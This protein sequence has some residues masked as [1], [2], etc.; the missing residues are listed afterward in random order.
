[1]AGSKEQSFL[2][3]G[4][5]N[6]KDAMDCFRWH[7]QSKCHSDAVQVMVVLPKSVRDVGKTITTAYAQ[8]KAENRKVLMKILQNIK[9]LGHQGI[10]LW[11][12]DDS[13]S[14]FIQLLKLRECDNP[15]I[16]QWLKRK[17]NKYLSPVCRTRHC[18]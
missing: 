2:L 7:G 8:N 1:M 16:S 6:W 11:G 18:N 4:F 5:C 12:H 15:E 17:G 10:A 14:N 9:F 13:E 3:K